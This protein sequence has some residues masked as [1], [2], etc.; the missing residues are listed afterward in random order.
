MEGAVDDDLLSYLEN[1]KEK[2]GNLSIDIDHTE[3]LEKIY[4][5]LIQVERMKPITK[6]I[7]CLKDNIDDIFTSHENQI[8]SVHSQII[9]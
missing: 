7:S 6:Y 4:N 3:S 9:T 1:I 5:V 2:I 8:N